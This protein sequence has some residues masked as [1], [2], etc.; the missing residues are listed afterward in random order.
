LGD[1]L[2]KIAAEKAGII[3]P[4]V[5]VIT[6]ASQPEVLA[7]IEHTAKQNGSPLTIV[8]PEEFATMPPLPLPG[9]HQ[10]INAAVALA[11]VEA[12]QKSIPVAAEKMGAGLA[13]VNWPGRFQVIEREAG[14]KIILDGAHNVE[15]IEVLRAALQGYFPGVRPVL[16][17]GVL[18]DKDWHRMGELLG[19]LAD[20]ILTVPV[21]SARTVPAAELAGFLRTVCPAAEIVACKGIAPALE[22]AKSEPLV[23][24][25]GSLYL[26]GEA[27]EVL[28][29]SPGEGERALNEWT[30]IDKGMA[31][32]G[33]G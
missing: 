14:R 25:A 18:A 30:S 9:S 20:R 31:S 1:T 3:K 26:I 4:G 32:K 21:A 29:L 17:L 7:V 33:Q 12:L 23:V 6:A 16:V 2:E 8:R 28:G 11:T 15:G 27:L 24:V 13:K 19:P 22:A 10:K 5:P